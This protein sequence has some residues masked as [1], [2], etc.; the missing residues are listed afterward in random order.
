MP[1]SLADLTRQVREIP[2]SVQSGR[3]ATV[4]AER[5]TVCGLD[6]GVGLGTLLAWEG[7]RGEVVALEEGTTIV[8]P[9]GSVAGLRPGMTLSPIPDPG[10]APHAGWL[11]RV[12]DAFGRPL[13]GLPLAPGAARGDASAPDPL[14]RRP[15]GERLDTGLPALDTILP[16]VRG[17]R[18][19]LF[20]GSGVGKSRLL[21][22]LARNVRADVIVFALLGE[23][24]RDLRV[25]L[26]EG[27]APVRDRSV[28]VVAGSDRP[29]LERRRVLETAVRAAEHFRDGGAHV[30]MLV[31]S[32]TRF[33]EAHREVALASGESASLRGHPPSTP[34]RLARLV[35]RMGPGSG[36]AGDITALMTVLVAGSDMEEP[37]ADMVR[38]L[39]DGHIVLDREIAER[40]R[41]PAIDIEASV[42]RALPDAAS[43]SENAMIAE[44][45]RL[46]ALAAEVEPLRRAGLYETGANPERDHAV[47]LAPI[48]DNFF[49]RRD[50]TTADAAFRALGDVL[51]KDR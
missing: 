47:V 38:G 5:I 31:D 23:R 22:D 12:L 21:L 37:V 33:A 14:T 15:L 41:F 32:L 48:L 20:A 44:T 11:G 1:F 42:S 27:L 3:V 9:H 25:M 28:A 46:M 50:L 17:Q 43:P 51:L 8:S 16:L 10:R 4:A 2:R 6:T 45:R 29:A 13:D 49:G 36:S 40:G 39:L 24:G 18:L 34:H 26:D 35:E 7:G 19:G 30:L